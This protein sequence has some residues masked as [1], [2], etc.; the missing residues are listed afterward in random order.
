MRSKYR[1]ALGEDTLLWRVAVSVRSTKVPASHPLSVVLLATF[2]K[3]KSWQRW[4]SLLDDGVLIRLVSVVKAHVQLVIRWVPA[5][6][7]PVT[8]PHSTK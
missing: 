6:S 8:V 4:P 2:R 5:Q 7:M 1:G 3:L